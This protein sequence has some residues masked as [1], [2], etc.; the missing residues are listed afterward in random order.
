MNSLGQRT[1]C[2]GLALLPLLLGACATTP[3]LAPGLPPDQ[4]SVSRDE[5]GG[6]ASDPHTAALQRLLDSPWGW[7]NDRQDAF[8]VPLS[9]WENWK[10]VRFWGVPSFVGFRYGDSHHAVMALWVKRLDPGDSDGDPGICIDRMDRWAKPLSSTYRVRMTSREMARGSWKTQGDVAIRSV[11]AQ[12]KALLATRTYHG[13]IAASFAWPRVCVVYGYAFEAGTAPEVSAKVR[14]RY[15]KE[16]FS[17][18]TVYDPYTPP[19]GVEPLP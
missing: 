13:T 17:R 3:R 7:R 14:D 12:V 6:N 15:V 5:P 4:K 9:D 1:A 11:D 19:E 18:L 16:A 8:H 2:L 10:R